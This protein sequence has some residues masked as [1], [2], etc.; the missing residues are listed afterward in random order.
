MNEY[1]NI[2]KI[3]QTFFLFFKSVRS[4]PHCAFPGVFEPHKR[5]AICI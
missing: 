5:T 2:N 4:R 1:I 3:K